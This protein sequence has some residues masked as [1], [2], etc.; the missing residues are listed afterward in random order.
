MAALC[1]VCC[2]CLGCKELHGSNHTLIEVQQEYIPEPS[3]EVPDEYDEAVY[4]EL[5]ER[6]D[7]PDPEEVQGKRPITKD[8]RFIIS[9]FTS[10]PLKISVLKKG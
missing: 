9:M 8:H 4:I 10:P 6:P 7:V 3:K 5:E 2:L 1:R